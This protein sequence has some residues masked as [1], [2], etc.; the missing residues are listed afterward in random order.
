MPVLEILPLIDEIRISRVKGKTLFEI[1]E[2]DQTF[3]L[4]VI[5]I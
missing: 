1:A 2:T 5:T 3:K 4:F